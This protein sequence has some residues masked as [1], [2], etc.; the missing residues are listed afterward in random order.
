MGIVCAASHIVINDGEVSRG[1]QY[2]IKRKEGLGLVVEMDDEAETLR[3]ETLRHDFRRPSHVL[4]GQGRRLG[5]REEV[6]ICPAYQTF[7]AV[8]PIKSHP[9]P[10]YSS[11]DAR[12]AAR[13]RLQRWTMR[14]L[15]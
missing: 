14:L 7:A 10:A 8:V 4:D 13:L 5:S 15:E 11:R 12:T 9:G 3:C 6:L 2:G 1:K